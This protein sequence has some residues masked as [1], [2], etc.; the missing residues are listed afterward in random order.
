MFVA[1]IGTGRA[2]LLAAITMGSVLCAAQGPAVSVNMAGQVRALESS[3]RE[4]AES[5]NGTASAYLAQYP[6]YYAQ[7]IVRTKS[8]EVEIHQQFDELMII[9][10]GDA[11]VMTGGSPESP[12]SIRPGE[13]RS[14]SAPGATPIAMAKGNVIHLL[15]GTPHQVIV[16][17]GGFIAYIDV[18]VAHAKE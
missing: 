2:V 15:A 3:L 12:H 5:G 17:A 10:D 18:K 4:Q 6:R 16:L 13:L 14:S 1:T 7:L 9:L 11:K 8:G